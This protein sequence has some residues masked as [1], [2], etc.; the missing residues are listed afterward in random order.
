MLGARPRFLIARLSAIGDCVQTMPVACALRERFPD[1]F[2]A[3]VVGAPAA[4]LLE[5]HP[6]IDRL[7]VVQKGWIKS[8]RAVLE[9]R[10][11]L[12]LLRPDVALD[13]QGLTQSA[14]AARLSGAPRRIGLAGRWGREFSRWMN[15]VRVTPRSPHAVCRYLDL[16]RP[17]GIE[18]PAVHFAVPRQALA[19]ETVGTFLRG[20]A[21]ARQFAAINVGAGWVS[22]LW[23]AERF[24]AIARHLGG[25]HGLRSIVVWAG[26]EEKGIAEQVVAAAAGHAVLAPPTTL[27]E[28]A[29]LVRVAQLFVGSDTGPLHLA[30]AVDT[31]CVALFGPTQPEECGP[32][33]PGHACVR[34]PLDQPVRHRRRRSDQ[35]AILAISPRQVCDAVDQ[36]LGHARGRAERGIVDAGT[37]RLAAG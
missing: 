35:S 32:F 19:E 37:G 18:A 28:L 13:P 14:L 27:A 4:P 23:P 7:V 12:R 34:A 11:E 24:A 36:L 10:R 26:N 9:L 1:A 3:W 20:L 33:G 17:L 15:N 16:L 6:A 21:P 30:A 2:I 29:A 8:S 25:R 5:D 22:K 31:P